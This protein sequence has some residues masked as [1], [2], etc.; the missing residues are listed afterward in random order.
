VPRQPRPSRD[1]ARSQNPDA[2]RAIDAAA[3]SRAVR[4]GL[5]C[6]WE[7]FTRPFASRPTSM[8]GPDPGCRDSHSG[9]RCLS[10]D[11]EGQNGLAKA[12]RRSGRLSR[13]GAACTMPTGG[14]RPARMKMTT[15]GRDVPPTGCGKRA[16]GRVQHPLSTRPYTW[17]AP[18]VIHY[19]ASDPLRRRLALG[20]TPAIPCLQGDGRFGW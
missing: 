13:F 15:R 19:T 1:P 16:A 7:P 6:A 12:S 17:R 18:R 10:G 20:C 11:A 2:P 3:A 4:V 9:R 5:P 8:R 14:I